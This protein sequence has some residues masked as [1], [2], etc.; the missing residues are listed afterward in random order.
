MTSPISPLGQ[1]LATLTILER[2]DGP[3]LLA[4]HGGAGPGSIAGFV[5]SASA[6]AAVLA[7]THPGFAGTP[8]PDGFEQIGQLADLYAAVLERRGLREVLVV[9]FSMGGWVAAELA[10][11]AGARLRGLVLV[12]A[13]GL[14]APREPVADVFSLTPREI[15]ALSYADPAPFFVDPATLSDERRAQMAANFR[16]LAAYGGREMGDAALAARLGGIATP[17]LVAWGEHDRIASPAYGRAFAAAIPGARFETIAG[18]G[19]L[20]QIERPEALRRL[21]ADFDAGLR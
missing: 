17:T 7:P 14:Q 10:L 18:C 13:V 20:P 12:D 2:G 11:R 15:A 21:L 3:P 5:E 4:L 8:R 16:A 6:S 9:G 19:H 1:A